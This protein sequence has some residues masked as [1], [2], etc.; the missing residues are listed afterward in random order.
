MNRDIIYT[1]ETSTSLSEALNSLDELIYTTDNKGNFQNIYG[2]YVA[3]MG[4]KRGNYISAIVSEIFEHDIN[5]IHKTS[6]NRCLQGESFS[7]EWK[8]DYNSK[9]YYYL[10]SVAPIANGSS[11]VSGIVGIIKNISREKAV[12]RYHSE[13]EMMFKTLTNAAKSAILSVNENGDIEYC[14]P[15]TTELFNYDQTELLGRKFSV[16]MHDIEITTDENGKFEFDEK[17]CEVK[18]AE[19]LGISK[20]GRKIPIEF[21]ISAYEI[22]NTKHYVIIIQ[23][24]SERKKAE[25]ERKIYQRTLEKKNEEL[26]EALISLKQMQNQLVQSEK[27]ASLG[28][29]VAGIAHEIN[30]PLAFV[31]SNLNR[32]KEYFEDLITLIERWKELGSTLESNHQYEDTL[33][34]LS[35]FEKEIDLEFIL[36]DC[37]ELLHH[38]F[39]GI[40][41]IKKIVMQLRGFSHVSEDH[42]VDADINKA[43]EETLTIVWNELKY[44]VNVIKKYGDIPKVQCHIGEIK[45]IFINLFVN[46]AH[47]I[48]ERG[49]ITIKTFIDGEYVIIQISDT[50]KGMSPEVKSKIFDPFFTT[51]P[52]GKGTGLGLWICMSIIQKH[53]GNIEVESQEGRGST[54]TISLP[55]ESQM[56]E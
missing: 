8:L 11:S 6:H 19:F 43:I 10:S 30:N 53:N 33:N 40:D 56:N 18:N 46:A 13:I 31:S 47:A 23:N 12:N 55:I 29:L 52:V 1:D 48:E 24:I 37:Q 49:D 45:Q 34:R 26:Q 17:L 39:E 27:M 16:L 20:E 54:F 32:F 51:K 9:T 3:Q 38:N 4:L 36:T 14:N 25:Q 15:E 35:A 5:Q 42:A 22:L 21:N 2:R 41:R 28:A 7:Y 44:K 50:G